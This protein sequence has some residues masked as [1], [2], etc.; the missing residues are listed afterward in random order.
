MVIK[1]YSKF[2]WAPGLDPH[3]HIKFSVIARKLIM[4]LLTL[5]Q[6]CSRP[7]L[8]PSADR[9]VMIFKTLFRTVNR[10]KESRTNVYKTDAKFQST[11][12]LIYSMYKVFQKIN[13]LDV[14][15]FRKMISFRNVIILSILVQM[16]TN[17]NCM[18]RSNS[19]FRLMFYYVFFLFKHRNVIHWGEKKAF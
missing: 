19:K 18:C 13:I 6:R 1:G 12:L 14:Q 17:F 3:H 5:I 16:I 2:L 15:C 7:I 11:F 9:V 4:G 10:W 8:L